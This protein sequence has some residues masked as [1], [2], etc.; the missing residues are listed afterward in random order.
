MIGFSEIFQILH[1]LAFALMTGGGAALI[2]IFCASD[3]S[4]DPWLAARPASAAALWLWAPATVI[5]PL[6]GWATGATGSQDI[7]SFWVIASALAWVVGA[8]ALAVGFQ[9]ARLAA[10]DG[11][12]PASIVPGRKHRT[13]RNLL[14]WIGGAALALAVPLMVLR[15]SF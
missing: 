3:R 9:Q 4:P 6:A 13:R 12:P 2:F 7:A 5:V 14:F 10:Q 8:G 11:R 15:P 1:V